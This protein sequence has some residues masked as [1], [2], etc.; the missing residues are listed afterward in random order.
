MKQIVTG[1]VVALLALGAAG[2]DQGS[3]GKSLL[4]AR[5]TGG[6]AIPNPAMTV[7]DQTA[8]TVFIEA[9]KPS[10]GAPTFAGWPSDH[11]TFAPPSGGKLLMAAEVKAAA[12]LHAPVIPTLRAQL[13]GG[14]GGGGGHGV[15]AAAPAA[16]TAATAG[17][18]AGPPNPPP[19]GPNPDPGGPHSNG[20]NQTASP[21]TYE[22]ACDQATLEDVRRNPVTHDYIIKNHLNSQS[23]LI[24]AYQT[25]FVVDLPTD[26]VEVKTNWLPV[27]LLPKYYPRVAASQFYVASF[28]EN[29]ASQQFALIAMHAISKQVPNWTWATFEHQ[30]NRGRCDFIG[31]HDAFGA[32]AANVPPADNGGTNQ[33]SVYANCAKSQALL[34][35]FKG[36]GVDAVFQNYCLKGAQADFTDGTG[37]AIRLG[38]SVTENGFVPQASC[39]TCH[40]EANFTGAGRPT[41]KFGFFN[42]SGQIGAINPLLAQYWTLAGAPPSYTPYQNMPGLVRN[43]ASADFLWAIPFCAYD[44]VTNPKVPTARC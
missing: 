15:A 3:G 23:G 36:A 44:D 39:M 42:G 18:K 30:A 8:W 4:A 40:G 38:N 2:C 14:A 29:G 24:K 32:V 10:G 31:C 20:C 43:A 6:A 16:A 21:Q 34:D 22:P 26:S 7:P 11:D 19:P 28:N 27:A 1:A 33:G 13:R 5:Q 25:N 35:L 37:L 12:H 9:V 17:A 41:S